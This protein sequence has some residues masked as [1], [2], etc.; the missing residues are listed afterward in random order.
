MLTQ[1][2]G[3]VSLKATVPGDVMTE[4]VRA[5]Q[6]PDPYDRENEALVQWIGDADWDYAR[7]FKVPAA[8]LREDQLVLQ[9]DGLDTFA[10]VEINGTA[11]ASTDNMHRTYEWDVKPLLKAGTN[12][13][14]VRFRSVN[15]YTR[16]CFKQ[17]ALYSRV[18]ES[19]PGR[20]SRLCAQGSV[21]LRLG[22]GP[23]PGH[24]RDL[25][26]DPDCRLQRGTAGGCGDR[27]DA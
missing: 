8:M 15:D 27:A 21:Q 14:R 7:D 22:L 1:V 2:G 12:S 9:C 3:A 5:K 13:I 17:R 25:A 16:A 11:V 4:L 6:V 24:Q 10:D 19:H 18:G 26:H 23:D 20:L